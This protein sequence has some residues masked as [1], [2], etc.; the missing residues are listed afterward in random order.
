M[1]KAYLSDLIS[2]SQVIEWIHEKRKVTIHA[3]TG[4]GKTYFMINVLLMMC[5]QRGKK[6]LFLCNRRLLREQYEFDLAEKFRLYEE[7]TA[8]V[9]VKTYQE[10]AELLKK[11][12]SI[13]ECLK[14]ADVI[15]MDEI[16]Y[17]YTDSDFNAYGTYVLF[18]KLIEATFFKT[19]IML[20]ATLEEVLPLIRKT[21][22]QLH[23]KMEFSNIQID[24]KKFRW[25][26]QIYDFTYLRDNSRFNGIYVPDV[27]SLVKEIASS[28]KKSLIFIDDKDKAAKFADLLC[29]TKMINKSDITILDSGILDE[30][31]NTT[32]IKTITVGNCLPKKILITTSVLDNGVSIHDKELGNMVIS[33][34]DRVSF[35]QMVGRVRGEKTEHCKLFVYPHKKSYYDLR[36]EQYKEKIDFIEKMEKEIDK[37]NFYSLLLEGWH[38]NK[39]GAEMFRNVVIPLKVSDEYYSSKFP[40]LN[41]RDRNEK[42]GIN[43]FSYVKAGNNLIA[44]K[45]FAKM[46]Y[47]DITQIAK[48]QL[49]WIGCEEVE[50]RKSS[51]YEERKSL[52]CS[53]LLKVKGYTNQQLIEVKKELL[54]EFRKDLLSGS[55]FKNVSFSDDK[56]M[57]LCDECG[58]RFVKTVGEDKLMRY[59][60]IKKDE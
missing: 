21:F 5:R 50:I 55:K 17:F 15:V 8:A 4:L 28:D 54:K 39:E 59:S 23:Q 22:L 58:L 6:V 51:F 46:A 57:E 13:A 25:S 9:D 48:V 56:L 14:D 47:T 3:P 26:N 40:Y 16:H 38:A 30:S 11:G 52:L 35:V 29:E 34:E 41:I 49:S 24:W 1:R 43:Y 32:E 33:T 53:M 36:V 18:Q 42:F 10:L 60:I 37:R 20:T 45:N 44:E 12:D 2:D 7:Q 31:I 27:E 19:V